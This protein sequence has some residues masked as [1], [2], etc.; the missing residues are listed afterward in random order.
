MM[1]SSVRKF[2]SKFGFGDC[3]N[4]GPEI[5]IGLPID[6]DKNR[7]LVVCHPAA[8]TY[9][10]SSM[11]LF[12][13]TN[14]PFMHIL[15]D[16]GDY[17][18]STYPYVVDSINHA[19][20]HRLPD[21]SDGNAIFRKASSSNPHWQMHVVAEA[22]EFLSKSPPIDILYVDWM[23]WLDKFIVNRK[24]SFCDMISHYIHKIRDGGLIIIDDKHEN[25][26]QW[27]NFPKKRTRISEDSEIE[28][29]CQIEWLGTDLED[30]MKS[31]SAKVIKVYH[32]S[33]GKLGSNDWFDEIKQWFWNSIPEMA[34]DQSQISRMIENKQNESIHHLA[35]TWED[36]HDTW[37]DVY[38]DL[39]EPY[40]HPVPP[41][42]AWPKDSYLKYLKWL[43]ENP[44]LLFEKMKKRTYQL[45]N[46][47]F[48]LTLIH[49]D[50]VELAPTLYCRDGAIAVR[51]NLQQRIISRCPW[52]KNQA[53]VLQRGK[54]WNY[55]PIKGGL[56]WSGNNSTPDLT[57]LLIEQSIKQPYMELFPSV[58]PFKCRK[59]ITISHSKACLKQLMDV[60]EEFFK[61]EKKLD[62]FTDELIELIIVHR[63]KKDY[64]EFDIM[65][66][67]EKISG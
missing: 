40:L 7:P 44:K 35:V 46:Y 15:V 63:D 59:I 28:F 39:N 49:G 6:I 58:K 61:T 4:Y 1:S 37:R 48:K 41:I 14:H 53:T 45:Q 32:D 12:E 23:T 5:G 9:Y 36:W 26:E 34:L 11:S 17:Y 65:S 33:D 22:Y 18:P 51:E 19:I 60:C 38:M 21:S 55:N 10:H 56:I 54:L 62:I 42:K 30:K 50:I 52:W 16:F 57:R 43:N 24:T 3:I 25:I 47:N 67:W 2:N 66:N 31:Y 29:Q 27:F 8:G 64:Q 13:D 20:Y